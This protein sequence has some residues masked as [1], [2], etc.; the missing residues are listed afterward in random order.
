ME[1]RGGGSPVDVAL[2]AAGALIAAA[3]MVEPWSMGESGIVLLR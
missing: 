1:G 2:V 3:A